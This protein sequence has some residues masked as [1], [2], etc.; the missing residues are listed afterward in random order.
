MPS[1]D[2]QGPRDQN[3]YS[4]VIPF[5]DR[6][7]GSRALVLPRLLRRPVRVT[8]R[9]LASGEAFS[10][11]NL[12]VAAG[13]TAMIGGSVAIAIN[14]WAASIVSRATAAAGIHIGDIEV[15]GG[16]EVSKI[17]VLAALDLGAERSLLVFDVQKAREKLKR[18]A[19]V[20]DAAVAKAYPHTVQIDLIER[21]PFAIWQRGD[22]LSL[23]SRDGHEIIPFDDRY[24]GLPLVVGA[25]ANESAAQI[26]AIAARYPEIG[27][28]A[29]AYV[30]VGRRR[31][32]IALDNGISLLLPEEGVEKTL[33]KVT[34]IQ[35]DT[36][37]FSRGIEH[38]DLR[39]ENRLVLGLTPGAAA[40]LEE[41]R[42]A[43]HTKA[44]GAG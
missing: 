9:W 37:I 20:A 3:R 35:N 11:R 7:D 33:V 38:V 36:D 27:D 13:V 19:W 40:Q 25:G 21:V 43:Q 14:G 31:W 16:R 28:R 2:R 34:K 8:G 1:I 4:A 17:D 6:I 18:L 39:L 12:A 44:G 22:E 26:L 23:I 5:M 10:L 42:K 41:A 29:V 24:A 15:R 32:N 30:R